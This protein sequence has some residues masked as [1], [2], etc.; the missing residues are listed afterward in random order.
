MFRSARIR[1]TAWYLLI[2]MFISVSFSVFI[3]GMLST[4]IDRFARSQR[5]RILRQIQPEDSAAPPIFVPDVIEV[6]NQQVAQLKN[7]L[8]ITLVTIDGSILVISGVLGFFLAGLTLRPIKIM[9]DDQNRFISDSSHELRTPLT[10][11]KSSL[12]VALRDP[13]FTLKEAKVLLRDSISDVDQL[14]TLS[15]DLLTL[16]RFQRKNPQ[17]FTQFDLEELIK[18]SIKRID[19]I[20]KKKKIKIISQISNA[21]LVACKD[22]LTQLITIILDNAIKYSPKAS[23]I[24]ISAKAIDANFEVKIQDHGI[25]I[26][27][28]DIPKIFD[29]FYRADSARTHYESGGFG[30]GLSIAKKIVDSYHGSIK[31]DSQLACGTTFTITLPRFSKTSV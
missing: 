12:E 11:L 17:V 10:A 28:K 30:L 7:R 2:I 19:P 24:N 25:G 1:L 26:D 23:E 22:T 21:N 20:A 8:F 4:E 29:R 15:N 3:Y 27:N 13:K 16:A 18:S 5:V 9:V 6:D 14:T 31:V